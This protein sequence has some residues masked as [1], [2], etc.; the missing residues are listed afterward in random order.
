MFFATAA[1][2]ATVPP[3]SD[4]WHF[5]WQRRRRHT[6]RPAQQPFLQPVRNR[7]YSASSRTR[8]IPP[9]PRSGIRGGGFRSR[10]APTHRPATPGHPGTSRRPRPG[11]NEVIDQCGC[12]E[13]YG[14]R[15]LR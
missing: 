11:A 13:S 15:P 12:R 3:K 1:L 10:L 8:A 14:R 7:K 2:A 5:G 9:A 6:G 4:L